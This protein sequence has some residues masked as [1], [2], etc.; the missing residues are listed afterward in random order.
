MTNVHRDMKCSVSQYWQSSCWYH[1]LSLA[2]RAASW[3]IAQHVVPLDLVEDKRATK[4]LYTWKAQKPFNEGKYF[5]ERLATD[6]L[7]ENDLLS[8]LSEPVDV[9][10]ARYLDTAAIP[11]WL[12]ALQDAFTNYTVD[13]GDAIFETQADQPFMLYLQPILPLIRRGLARLRTD[14]QALECQYSFLPFYS[15]GVLQ[16]FVPSLLRRLLAQ[17]D[18]TCVLEMH[19]ARLQGRLQGETSEER[20]RDFVRQLCQEE[21]I[22]ALLEEYPVLARQLVTTIDYWAKYAQE[23]LTHLCA[24][25]Q[26]ILSTFTPLDDPGP[27]VEL[28][29]GAGDVHRQ[30]RSV[31]ILTFRSG[32]QLLYKPRSLA[33]D[34]HFQELL[35]WLNEYGAQ[36]GFRPITILSREDYGWCEFVR[37]HD[38]TSADAVARFYERQGSYLALLYVLNAIDFHL[39]NLIAAGEHPVLVDL[40]ALFHPQFAGDNKPLPYRLA[41]IS[42]ERSVFRIGLLPHRMWSTNEDPGVDLSGLGGQEGQLLPHSQ[43][44]WEG[45]GTDQMRLTRQYFALSAQ[46][47]RPRLNGQ[48]VEV[49]DYQDQLV[50]GF[51]NMY[52]LL[53]ARRDELLT[54]ILPRFA[55]DEIRVLLRS[56]QRYATLLIESFHPD[57]LRDALERNRIFDHL[58]QEIDLRPYLWRVIPAEQLNLSQGDIPLFTTYPDSCTL[59][60]S[61]SEPLEGLLDGS[62]LEQ[63]K[64]CLQRLGE[65]DLARQIWI[66]KAALTTLVVDPEQVARRYLQMKPPQSLATR[67]RLLA[68]ARAIGERLEGLVMSD[69]F[70]VSWLGV[71]IVNDRAWSLLPASA[72]LYD[73]TSGIA[74]FLAYLGALTG[75]ARY[76][77]LARLALAATRSQLDMQKKYENATSIGVFVDNAGSLLYLLVHL[78]V[79]WQEPT[80]LDEATTLVEYLA[81]FIT[82]DEQFDIIA[83]SA[84]CILN[85]LSLYEVH[86]SPRILEVAMLCGERLLAKA[87]PMSRGIAWTTIKNEKPLGGFSHGTAGIALSLLKLAAVSNETHYREAALAALEYDRSLFLPDKQNWADIRALSNRRAKVSA[88]DQSGETNAADQPPQ[89][90]MT[91]WCHGAGGIGLA[92]LAAL[93]YQ[94]DTFTREEI[95]IA[96]HTIMHEGLNG[97]HSLCHGALGNIDTVLVATQVLKE[98]RYQEWLENATAMVLES[99]EEGGWVTG[100]PRGIET[101]GL[102]TGIA[103]IGY[104]LLRLAEPERVPSVL[105]I[106]PPRA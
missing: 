77:E 85:L 22:L 46:Q 91:A 53:L 3:R 65:Q 11:D 105:L 74:L 69:Q 1:A 38:C 25:W 75:E 42:M 88:T 21:S 40:E 89:A 13:E 104:E 83:G 32:F 33:I 47:N 23:V 86:A 62:S 39:E 15:E 59:F 87:Q 51:I 20:F 103:G 27:L 78:S 93:E 73:G 80:L 70:G 17:L 84:G 19:V 49:L 8:L 45:A 56:S 28:Q 41:L 106:A 81:V 31:S 18:K 37:V 30:G 50:K 24:D 43:P 82:R 92:R 57:L 90:C 61:R 29:G 4:R 68:A 6:A 36:P 100:I 97:N 9:L 96:L 5:T 60:T 54:N 55:H 66:I 7:T 63:A 14:V 79:L 101:P 64:Q 99:I 102:M 95:A 16:M 2:E 71:S 72:N 76:T 67:E 98:S 35:V 58:W 44:S 52:R 34:A 10:Q 94:D 48:E 26:D 12:I